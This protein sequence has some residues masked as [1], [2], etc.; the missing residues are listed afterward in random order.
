MKGELASQTGRI[1]DMNP[2]IWFTTVVVLVPLL[3]WMAI[4]QEYRRVSLL[5]IFLLVLV[6]AAFLAL[7]RV[8]FSLVL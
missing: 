8:F 4:V 3:W 7:T 2:Q 5:S 6:E 1:E